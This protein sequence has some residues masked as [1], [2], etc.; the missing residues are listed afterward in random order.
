MPWEIENK[1]MELNEFLVRAKI[2]TYA[3]SGEGRVKYGKMSEVQLLTKMAKS[4][5]TTP[6]SAARVRNIKNAMENRK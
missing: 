4:A 6:V 1:T 2:N 3:S 5:G